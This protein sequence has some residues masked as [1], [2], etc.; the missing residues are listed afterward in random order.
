M[1]FDGRSDKC[2]DEAGI[3]KFGDRST[4]GVILGANMGRPI[5]T[6]GEFSAYSC[7]KELRLIW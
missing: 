4:G 7:A 2:N 6:N 1:R 5:V 3:V